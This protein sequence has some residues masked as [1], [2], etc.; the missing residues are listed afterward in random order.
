MSVGR[1]QLP[2]RERPAPLRGILRGNFY[3]R[4]KPVG[5]NGSLGRISGFKEYAFL[6]VPL[7][8]FGLE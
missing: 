7:R 5:G 3:S 2:T 4:F 8:Y 6:L 1:W